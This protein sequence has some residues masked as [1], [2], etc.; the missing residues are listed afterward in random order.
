MPDQ[1]PPDTDELLRRAE[2]DDEA[3][4][5]ALLNRHRERLRHMVGVR[6]DPRLAARIDPSDVVQEALTE[7]LV[8]LPSYLRNRPVTFYPWLRQI[9][10][11]R[12][13]LL[14]TQH[15][16]AQK[17][18]VLKE[19]GDVLPLPDGSAVKLVDR[20]IS[21]E[22]GPS[23]RAARKEI[24]QRLRFAVEEL[25]SHY[26]E[27]IILRH[28]EQLTFKEIAGVLGLREAATRSRYRRA[29]ERLHKRLS[30]DLSGDADEWS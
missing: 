15:I 24:R 26:R 7:A 17:R 11:E 5:G 2:D 3:A 20:L 18:S 22:T 4:I 12:L 29:V 6:I 28:L 9:A 25:P 21:N 23:L 16:R 10:W 19:G 27:V 8:K 30:G 14:H 13:V 1:S